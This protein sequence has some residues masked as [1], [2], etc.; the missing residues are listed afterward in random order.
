MNTDN[1]AMYHF[2][3][4]IYLFSSYFLWGSCSGSCSGNLVKFC[5]TAPTCSPIFIR[6]IIINCTTFLLP[7]PDF[8]TKYI[9]KNLLSS[10]SPVVV[11][12]YFVEIRIRKY[13]CKSGPRT[14]SRYQV[15]ENLFWK[16]S[17]DASQLTVIF[18]N[19]M[20]PPI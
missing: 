5:F 11:K 17:K 9:G 1:K 14:S 8:Y 19:Q 2:Y 18:W 3:N 15:L 12:S 16:P 7:V 6:T 13:L 4:Y 10:S 20:S